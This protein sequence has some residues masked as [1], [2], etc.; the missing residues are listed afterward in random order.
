[1]AKIDEI[2]PTYGCANMTKTTEISPTYRCAITAEHARITS[3]AII[4]GHTE[5]DKNA[6]IAGAVIQKR[7]SYAQRL[8]MFLMGF[9]FLFSTFTACDSPTE[10]NS[11]TPQEKRD[12][13]ELIFDGSTLDGWRGLN[14]QEVPDLYWVVENGMIYKI[15]RDSI[16]RGPDGNRV[17]GRYLL[18]DRPLK[19][20]E[21]AFEWNISP[22][23]NSGIKYN[24]L[25]G[26][27]ADHGNPHSALGFEYQ[28]LD[29]PEYPRLEEHPSWAT[30]GLYD[31]VAPGDNAHLNPAGEW[32]SGRI[33][34]DGNYGEHWLNGELVL[35]F[36]L[37]SPEMDSALAASKWSNIEEFGKRHEEAYVVLQDHTT[38]V[39]FR[40]L[41]L[42]E[43]P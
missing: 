22:S 24:V 35:S 21:L 43:L 5:A 25:E 4:A 11:L 23:G 20:F 39:R 8:V 36:E 14:M 10:I 3:T 6:R 30:S 12:G 41:K 38:P 17:S 42:R 18:L 32:N 28:I 27:S 16:P 1:M 19:N 13:W 29:D 37:D 7:H 31:L 15:H 26:L 9:L 40:N 2:T 34:F 33:L